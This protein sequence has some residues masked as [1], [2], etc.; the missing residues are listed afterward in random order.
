MC[1]VETE[2]PDLTI[3]IFMDTD[4]HCCVMMSN[5]KL[6]DYEEES[7]IRQGVVATK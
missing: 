2:Y 7:L 4:Q 5:S 6:H 3:G 1:I